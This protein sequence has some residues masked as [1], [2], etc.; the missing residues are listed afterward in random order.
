MRSFWSDPYLWIHLA[1]AAVLPI[2][3]ELCLLGLAIGDPIFPPVIEQFLVLSAGIAPIFWMQWQRPFYIFSVLFVGVQPEYLTTDQRRILRRFKSPAHQVL[4]VLVAIALGGVFLQLYRIA[5]LVLEPAARFPQWRGV[6]LLTAALAFLLTNLFL[7]IPLSVLRVM[8][9][10]DVQFAATEPYAIEQIRPNFSIFG[11]R[12]RQIFPPLTEPQ[13]EA[14]AAAATAAALLTAPA[15]PPVPSSPPVEPMPVAQVADAAITTPV[16]NP[17]SD[18]ALEVAASESTTLEVTSLEAT[19]PE[20]TTSEATATPEAE[21]VAEIETVAEAVVPET[22]AI[23][24]SEAAAIATNESLD[25]IAV[26]DS[27]PANS[28]DED[29][30]D[31]AT[32]ESEARPAQESEDRSANSENQTPEDQPTV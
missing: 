4:T 13:A 15:V 32:S 19:V 24:I 10:S 7:Q 20:A 1:G 17:A 8:L 31:A 25:A 11:W 27:S 23:A 29:A 22:A 3:L 12:V 16:E 18:I 14:M 5:P 21:A 6:G 28:P 26:D 2:T 9:T 30:A